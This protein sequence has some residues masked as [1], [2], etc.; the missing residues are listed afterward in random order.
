MSESERT[1]VCLLV[2]Y[3]ATGVA[4]GAAMFFGHKHRVKQHIAL[5]G[6]F[7]V[8]FAVT[9]YFADRTG[10]FF[11]FEPRSKAIH[12]PLAYTAT[13]CSLLPLLTGF[14]HWRGKSSLR[15]H[16]VAILVFLSVFAAASV[17]GVLML[18]TRS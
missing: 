14:L 3:A 11:T 16:R 17:T 18:E 15:A 12:L 6:V 2:S 13:G 4:L 9:V 10:T 7:L 8:G 5:I 1:L